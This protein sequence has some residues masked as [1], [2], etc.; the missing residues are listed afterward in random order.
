M[1]DN[2][3]FHGSDLIATNSF[4]TAERDELRREVDRLEAE[5]AELRNHLS[6]K[7]SS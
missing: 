5:N 3:T 4:L 1:S 7:A 6:P 2:D